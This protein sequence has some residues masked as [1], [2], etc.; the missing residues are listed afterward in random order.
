[1]FGEPSSDEYQPDFEDLSDSD[2]D[3]DFVASRVNQDNILQKNIVIPDSDDDFEIMNRPNDTIM[4]Q[5]VGDQ[6][7]HN[8]LDEDDFSDD[9]VGPSDEDDGLPRGIHLNYSFGQEHPTCPLVPPKKRK[10]SFSPKLK[11]S[12]IRPRNPNDW[13]RR[14]ASIARQKGEEYMSYKGQIIPAKSIETQN[15]CTEKCRLKCNQNVP[16]DHRKQ[17][18]SQFHKLDVNGKNAILFGSIS[19]CPVKRPRKGAIKHKLASFKYSVTVQGNQIF[20]CKNALA[21]LYQIGKKKID[22]IQKSMKTGSSAPSPDKRGRHNSRPHKTPDEVKEYIVQHIAMFPAEESHY[23]RHS[24]IYKKYLSPLLS[25]PKLH[26]LYLEKCAE[27]NVP[28]HYRVTESTYRNVFVSKFNLSFGHPKSDTCST[29]DAGHSNE[30]HIEMFHAAFNSLKSDRDNAKVANNVAY[31]TIDLQQTMPLPRLSTSKAFYLRQ[32]WLYNLGIHILTKKAEQTICCVWT[33][34]QASRGSKEITS[35]LLTVLECEAIFENIDHLVIWSD[36]CS[37]Q[38]KNFLTICLYQYL[39]HKR[40]FKTVDHKFPE[41]G[42]TYLDSDRDFGRIEKNL[43]KHQNIYS[44]KEYRDIIA[45]S[46]KKNKVLDMRDHFRETEDLPSKLKLYNRKVDFAKNAVKF[47]DN[48]KWIRV[49][50]YGS[51]LYKTCYD[52]YTPFMK[53]DICK[54]SKQ[55]F[56]LEGP[57][58]IS[59]T[60]RPYGT[61]KKEKIENIKEQLKFIPEH[62]RW[63]YQ[64]IIDQYQIST[65]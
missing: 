62:H 23:S 47:R 18:L 13:K 36:S 19:I 65:V 60:L 44:P 29:C 30:E 33:E 4:Q 1:M 35:S 25:V 10:K 53:V 26:K 46:S 63:W 58:T 48:V 21:S 27:D 34:D 31:L 12:K 54:S 52:D 8:I 56:N 38:N 41:V 14:K 39:I 43:R 2:K 32:L 15:L 61:L 55:N 3:V 22:L 16:I 59:R 5:K 17:I 49:D 6:S 11:I 40:L 51:Y 28:Q 24:N 42:H 37:G 9:V 57:I 45:K 20:I 64:Q 7:I 50:E